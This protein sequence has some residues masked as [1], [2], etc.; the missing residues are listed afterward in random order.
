MNEALQNLS[1]DILTLRNLIL[2]RA[3]QHFKNES[4]FDLESSFPSFGFADNLLLS[5]D[6]KAILLI[7]LMPHLQPD[8]YESTIQEAL[9]QGGD[10]PQFGGIRGSNHRGLLPTGETAQFIVAGND[11]GRRIAIQN[12]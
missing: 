3:Q 5:N 8:F 11:L 1:N 4:D 7:A 9:P 6:E 10:F 12:L 2:Q